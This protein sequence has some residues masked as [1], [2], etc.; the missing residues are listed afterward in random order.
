MYNYSKLEQLVLSTI[1]LKPELIEDKRLEDKYFISSKRIWSFMKAFYKKFKNFDFETMCLA[2]SN[3][4]KIMMYISEL[5]EL[6]PTASRFEEYLNLM[7]ELYNEE[8]K[9]QWLRNKIYD[10][11]TEFYLKTIDYNTFKDSLDRIYK[12]AEEIFKK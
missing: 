7:I 9:E 6:E 10:L 8:R 12:N 1:L 11:A 4:Y 5:M 3:K 2:A